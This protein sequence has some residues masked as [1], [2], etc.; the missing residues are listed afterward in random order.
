MTSGWM[1]F[2]LTCTYLLA[3]KLSFILKMILSLLWSH[4]F[5]QLQQTFFF[6]LNEG[7]KENFPS[8]DLCTIFSLLNPRQVN[9]QVYKTSIKLE[10]KKK[11]GSIDAETDLPSLGAFTT[12]AEPSWE[13]AQRSILLVESTRMAELL[14]KRLSICLTWAL[15]EL[16]TRSSW[17]RNKLW[18]SE[19][20][21]VPHFN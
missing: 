3:L 5:L 2:L 8:S 11:K 21:Q 12:S 4:F 13:E 19:N 9:K 16:K 7:E 10:K 14:E 17:H 18:K 15:F 6:F 1:L 20:Q